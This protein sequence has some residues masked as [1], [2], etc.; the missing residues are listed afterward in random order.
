MKA[1][2][3]E[4]AQFYAALDPSGRNRQYTVL[5]AQGEY[6]GKPLTFLI[7]SGSLHSFISPSTAKRLRVEAQPMGKKLRASLANGSSILTKEQILKL[8]F[9][10]GGNPT[11]QE[12]RILKMGKFQGI[13]GMDWL[14]QDKAQINCG[15]GSIL[16]TSNLEAQVQI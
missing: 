9:Q 8:S 11:S 5:G 16:F 4:Q 7:D 2:G 14:G 15:L 12:F 1:E 13:L 10:L 3:E 6:E